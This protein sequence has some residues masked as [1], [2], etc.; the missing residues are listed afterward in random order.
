MK[1]KGCSKNMNK[2][3]PHK[4]LWREATDGETL[5]RWLHTGAGGIVPAS[6]LFL[7]GYR[8]RSKTGERLPSGSHCPI[9]RA[10]KR[11]PV[12]K[13]K[14]PVGIV[15]NLPLLIT[16]PTSII[17]GWY[18]FSCQM[19]SFQND[20]ERILSFQSRR[21]IPGQMDWRPV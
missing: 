3:I 21:P 17:K 6:F 20:G 7:N 8:I 9:N 18:H 12:L 4:D 5:Y 14:L 19:A 1:E 10:L 11:N 15:K 13:L 16:D 2:K